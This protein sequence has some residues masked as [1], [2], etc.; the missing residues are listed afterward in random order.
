MPADSCLMST[1][2]ACSRGGMVRSASA[3]IAGSDGTADAGDGGRTNPPRSSAA[4]SRAVIRPQRLAARR[5]PD[6][7]HERRT[8]DPHAG[9]VRRGGPPVGDVPAHHERLGEHVAQEAESRHLHRVAVG[10]RDDLEDLHL[11]QVAGLRSLDVH[12]AGQRVDHVQVRRGHRVQRGLRAHLPVERVAGLQHDLVAGFAADDRRDV[13]MPPVVPRR[14]LLDQ[15]LR[16]VDPYLVNCHVNP[17][18]AC[19]HGPGTA[20]SS[21][22]TTSPPAAVSAGIVRRAASSMCTRGGAG[23]SCS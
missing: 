5:Q 21:V 1:L 22:T 18:P 15:R 10:V 8:R 23:G 4:C 13:G 20:S 11:E 16:P 19:G 2:P 12:R 14:R 7:A 9:Q 6:R 17:S 3:A